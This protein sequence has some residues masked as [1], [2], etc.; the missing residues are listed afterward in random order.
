MSVYKQPKSKWYWCQ[1]KIAGTR[2]RR[3]TG[4]DDREQAEEF[5]H[6]LRARLWRERKLGERGAITFK[7][8]CTR[9]LAETRKRTKKQDRLTLDWFLSFPELAE[10]ALQDVDRDVI[11]RLRLL[12]LKGG[13]SEATVDRYMSV[14][15]AMLRKAEREWRYLERAPSVPMYRPAVPE[16]RWLTPQEF[17]RLC[18]ELPCHLMLAARFAALTGLRMR[19]MLRLTWDRVDTKTRRASR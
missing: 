16:A 4:T 5:E 18:K 19:S 2:V 6:A 11:E 1:V 7:E 8:A 3:S 15:R 10:S 13:R 14:L 9:W 12:L 17:D